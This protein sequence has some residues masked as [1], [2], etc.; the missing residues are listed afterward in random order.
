MKQQI[1]F[2]HGGET[3]DTYEQYVEYLKRSEFDPK[4]ESQKRWK[5]SLAEN[6]GDGY[7]ILMPQMPSKHN[8]KYNEWKIWFEKVTPFIK[9]NAIFIGHSLGGI[10]LTKYLSEN[11]FSKTIKATKLFTR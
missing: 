1:V 9:E 10:F 4:K 6:L 8:A 11:K 7:E 2:I 3:H 5:H